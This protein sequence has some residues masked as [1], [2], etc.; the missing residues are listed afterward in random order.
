M[1]EYNSEKEQIEALRK[2]W[3]ENGKY[4]IAGLI[5][6][7]AAVVGWRGWAHYRVS[8]GQ[9]ASALFAALQQAQTGGHGD[10][11][12]RLGAQLMQKYDDTPY[13]AQA[14]LEL[15][16]VKTTA[17]KRDEA[18]ADLMWAMKHADDE[19]VALIARLRLARLKLSQKNPK[20]A[21][22]LLD[23]AEPGGLMALYQEVKG[24]AE[25]ALGNASAARNAYELALANLTPQMG[26]R[27]LIQMKL[28]DLG[29]AGYSAKPLATDNGKGGKP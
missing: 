4:I 14:A 8:R 29:G 16:K 17:G 9:A 24:D 20:G 22:Q 13:A 3:A 18:A 21:I 2:W 10:Q 25:A 6:G 26:D 7:V 11:A 15:A 23:G 12:T 27:Q 5:L 1:N 19:G 28:Q